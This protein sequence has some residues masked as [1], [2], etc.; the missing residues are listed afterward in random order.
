MQLCELLRGLNNP[1]RP[2]LQATTAVRGRLR[3]IPVAVAGAVTC[4]SA[5]R[6]VVERAG[7]R[8]QYHPHKL[9][10]ATLDGV[11]EVWVRTGKPDIYPD[12]ETIAYEVHAVADA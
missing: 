5:C 12:C 8:Q 10:C 1:R 11:A 9:V 2:Q 4:R 3:G 7:E 6:E